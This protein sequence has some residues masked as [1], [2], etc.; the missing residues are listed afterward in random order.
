[1]H[2]DA[3]ERVL[4][5]LASD[6][7]RI[8]RGKHKPTYTPHMLMGDFVVVTNV[9]K[10]RFT[11]KKLDDK[12][13]YRHSGYIGSLRTF[14]LREML[15]SHP[16]R[17]LREAVQGMLPHNAQLQHLLGRLKVYKGPTH[18]H[19]AQLKGYGVTV[20]AR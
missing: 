6:I 7:A 20:K 9:E 4:G 14:T 1:V 3:T 10:M 17:I 2:I 19:E 18:P 11:G 13:Y 16:D 12:K 15:S 8:L 5:E